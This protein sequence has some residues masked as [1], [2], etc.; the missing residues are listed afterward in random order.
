MAG[1]AQPSIETSSPPPQSDNTYGISPAEV[2]VGNFFPGARAE[3]DQKDWLTIYSGYDQPQRFSIT[4]QQPN[5][6]TEGY[7]PA[8][9]EAKGWVIIDDPAPVLKARETRQV[10]VA[11]EMPKDAKAPKKWE[12][13]IAVNNESQTGMVQIAYQCKWLVTMKQ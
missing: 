13:W 8:P 10:L 11:L 7:V 5:K 3:P 1:C 9:P 6:A 2:D 4:Y 12:F